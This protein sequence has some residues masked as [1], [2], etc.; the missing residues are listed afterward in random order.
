VGRVSPPP[1][2]AEEERG[3][4]KG[5]GRRESECVSHGFDET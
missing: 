3:R 1:G 4:E 5:R 2:I